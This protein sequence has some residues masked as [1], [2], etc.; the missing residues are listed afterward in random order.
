M[1]HANGRAIRQRYARPRP[2]HLWDT[3]VTAF[4][5][6]LRSLASPA[7]ASTPVSVATGRSPWEASA[8]VNAGTVGWDWRGDRLEGVVISGDSHDGGVPLVTYL[9]G[10]PTSDLSRIEGEAHLWA[11]PGWTVF[12]PLVPSSG[13]LGEDRLQEARVARRVHGEDLDLDAVYAGIRS[14]ELGGRVDPERQALVGF[15]F[16]GY[17]AN[18]AI[19]T[20]N[21]FRA[22]ICIEAVADVRLLDEVST[23]LQVEWLGGSADA[24]PE[25][26]SAA[27]PIDHAD[28]VSTPTLLVYGGDWM[29]TPQA[30]VWYP[31]LQAAGVAVEYHRLP[32][33]GHV[34]D[35]AGKAACRTLGGAW[36]SRH[37]PAAPIARPASGSVH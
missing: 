14:L 33:Q 2:T 17:L 30:D 37:L 23:R 25:H 31:A 32:G 15:S 24:V 13:C 1:W 18:R 27:S 20:T 21:R 10:G 3:G 19:T 29:L 4:C 16:G 6:N 8:V 35:G 36:L 34:F 7:R 26:W 9:A 12:A 11:D 22:A 5:G 28:D